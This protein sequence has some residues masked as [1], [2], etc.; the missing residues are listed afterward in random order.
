MDLSTKLHEELI[1]EFI[2]EYKNFQFK[3]SKDLIEENNV[4]RLEEKKVFFGKEIIGNL[5]GLK[6]LINANFKRSKNI[7]N[8]KILDKSLNNYSVRIKDSFIQSSFS[9]FQIFI[10]GKIAWKKNVIGCFIKGKKLFE[11]KI[12]FFRWIFHAI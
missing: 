7:F 4:I 3:N 9:S 1:F 8:N 2:G 11:P 6:F 12:I 10:D 5:V